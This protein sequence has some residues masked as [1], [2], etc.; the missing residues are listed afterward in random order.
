MFEI[1]AIEVIVTLVIVMVSWLHLRQN[2]MSKKIDSKADKTDVQELKSDIKEILK[3]LTDIK[4][5]N[6]RWQGLVDKVVK[7]SHDKS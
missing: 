4:V 1:G 6:A 7:N 3:A 5:D 2:D